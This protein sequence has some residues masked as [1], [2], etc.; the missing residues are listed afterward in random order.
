[1]FLIPSS[2]AFFEYLLQI[3]NL[4][5]VLILILLPKKT[6]ILLQ[7]LENL[8][9]ILFLIV[10]FTKIAKYWYI[11][12]GII[13]IVLILGIITSTVSYSKK[14]IER[15]TYISNIVLKVIE[16][17]V[18]LNVKY[19]GVIVNW[20]LDLIIKFFDDLSP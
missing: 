12:A 6:G 2:S 3:K 20:I 17:I 9:F 8:I 14:E 15:S 5:C 16:I 18:V 7:K 13:T 19:I 1:M 10:I 4:I 11:F